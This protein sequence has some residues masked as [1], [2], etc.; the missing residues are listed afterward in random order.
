MPEQPIIQSNEFIAAEV[1]LRERTWADH[2]EPW[3]YQPYHLS[4]REKLALLKRR[5]KML[6]GEFDA[7]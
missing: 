2:D 7:D 3:Q 1:P 5:E 6:A 4:D